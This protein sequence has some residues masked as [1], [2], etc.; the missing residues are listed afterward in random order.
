[1][2]LNRWSTAMLTDVEK[3]VRSRRDRTYKDGLLPTLVLEK[4]HAARDLPAT[5]SNLLPGFRTTCDNLSLT[6]V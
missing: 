6:Q 1:M 5:R 3:K 4:G 2:R